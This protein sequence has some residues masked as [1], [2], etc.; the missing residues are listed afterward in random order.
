M[1]IRTTPLPT[2]REKW[3]IRQWQNAGTGA[4]ERGGFRR[5]NGGAPSIEDLAWQ[6]LAAGAETGDWSVW[7]VWIVE[8][9]PRVD[10]THTA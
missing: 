8:R 1:P 7:S 10:E 6:I 4:T 5:R 2:F 9:D 3:E